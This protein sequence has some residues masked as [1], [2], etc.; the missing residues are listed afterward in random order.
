[1]QAA[2]AP[3][4]TAQTSAAAPQQPHLVRKPADSTGVP[5]EQ[6]VTA[7]APTTSDILYLDFSSSLIS[8]H[9]AKGIAA[10]LEK[11]KYAVEAYRLPTLG[12]EFKDPKDALSMVFIDRDY[13]D[14]YFNMTD[15]FFADDIKKQN[16]KINISGKTGNEIMMIYLDVLG[17]ERVEIKKLSDFKKR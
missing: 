14:E 3:Q 9:T 2:L 10:V 12:M 11:E 8:D 17:N 7:S 4:G 6:A 16:Y 13:N 5:A 1:M 15:F